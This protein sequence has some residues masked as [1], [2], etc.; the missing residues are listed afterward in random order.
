MS[1]ED[2]TS[3]HAVSPVVQQRREQAYFVVI[4]AHSP[5]VVGKMFKLER[6]ETTLGRSLDAEFHIDD[7]GISRKHARVIQTPSGAYQLVDLGSTNGTFVNGN[8]VDI[9][10][11]VDGDQVQLGPSTVLKFSWQDQ[12][13]EQY[14]RSIYESATRDGLTRLFNKKYF[15][16]GLRKE[17]AYSVRRQTPLSVV[18]FDVDHFKRVNDT[19][20][21]LAGDFVLTQIA[22]RVNDVVRTEDVFARTGGEEFGLLLRESGDEQA[23][24]CAERC[25]RVVEGTD[26]VFAGTTIKVTIS[27]GLATLHDA[28]Y[29]QAEELLAE[30]D[31]YLYRAKQAG[32]NRVASKRLSGA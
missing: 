7:E 10:P 30:A 12:L 21:H 26:F 5:G 14:Q 22:Q 18:V 17:F 23:H 28:D 4:S 31:R 11:L 24:R 1:Q 3:V 15:I 13:E 29:S 20:G 16:E 8:P 32:R 19:Y 6:A 27:L 9:S 25:R 2:K